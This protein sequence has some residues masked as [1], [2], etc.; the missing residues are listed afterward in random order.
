MVPQSVAAGAGL[1]FFSGDKLVGGPQAG[2]IV[3][4]KELITRLRRHPLARAARIDKIRLAGLAVTLAHYL[5]GEALQK[6]PVW[7]MISRPLA[8]I[9]RRARTWAEAL[10]GQAQV[11]DG[12]SMV[13]GGSLPGSTLPSKLVAIGSPGKKKGTSLA[14][15]LAQRLRSQETPIIGRITGDVLLLDPRTVFPEEDEIVLKA[16]KELATVLK[17]GD[18]P[19]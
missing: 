2:L 16:L 19:Q 15:T 17:A 7:S 5:K 9:E 10:G 12:E 4:Q 8:E 1:V 3:G 14:Q 6:I 18:Q 11:I 13:G